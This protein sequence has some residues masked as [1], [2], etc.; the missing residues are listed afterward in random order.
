VTQAA[1]AFPFFGVVADFNGDGLPDLATANVNSD[2][3]SI[4]LNAGP[5]AKLNQFIVNDGSAQRSM[6][7][8]LTVGFSNVVTVDQGAFELTGVSGSI[9]LSAV[10][11]LL[12]G[13]T[14]VTLTFTDSGLIGSSLADGN[15]TLMV[16]G[17][18]VHDRLGRA[19]DGSGD[20]TP[21]SDHLET[22]FRLFGDGNGD[23]HVDMA[24]LLA[25]LSTFGHSAGDPA[26]L[27]YFDFNGDAIVDE[28]DFL[29]FA[30]RYG[31]VLNPP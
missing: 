25:F 27:A 4:L 23:R 2:D 8:S 26:F 19:L 21:G 3:V 10:P 17:D 31:T 9:G 6:V 30:S 18:H 29:Q 16:H 7:T 13:R 12:N 15:Y 14:V 1:G 28:A 5:L 22:F 20:G 11:A 24:D